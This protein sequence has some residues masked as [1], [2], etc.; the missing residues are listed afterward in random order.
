MKGACP[1]LGTI[2]KE[3][4]VYRGIVGLTVIVC[5]SCCTYPAISRVVSK[6]IRRWPVPSLG[7]H[8]PFKL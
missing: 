5:N 8:Q 6:V 1:I 3:V 7:E 4:F 2:S